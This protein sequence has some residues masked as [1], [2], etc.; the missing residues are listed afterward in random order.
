MS[1]E[2]TFNAVSARSR[3]SYRYKEPW[4][5]TVWDQFKLFSIQML[6]AGGAGAIAKTSVAPLERIKVGRASYWWLHIHH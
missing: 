4:S 5:A 3:S 1:E 2:K 6:S